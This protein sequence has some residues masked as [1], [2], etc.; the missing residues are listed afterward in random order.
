MNL[1]HIA[2]WFSKVS[3]S[4][5]HNCFFYH[6][7]NGRQEKVTGGLCRWARGLYRWTRR[8]I[9]E[10][11]AGPG[12]QTEYEDTVRTCR[13]WCQESQSPPGLVNPVRYTQGNQK[14]FYMCIIS[15]ILGC[16]M[17]STASG[18]GEGILPLSSALMRHTCSA[19]GLDQMIC[20][21]PCQPQLF[22]GIA[23]LCMYS[24]KTLCMLK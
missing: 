12:H 7:K 13:G 14:D 10:V 9:E 24:F 20:R 15:S 21:G 1:N 18:V 3:S 5:L 4:K 17:Q 23:S 6:A 19:W 22:C 2:S 8:G 11:K 16:I